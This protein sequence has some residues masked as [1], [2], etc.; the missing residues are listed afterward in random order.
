MVE[1]VGQ[2][3][4]SRQRILCTPDDDGHKSRHLTSPDDHRNS[5]PLCNVHHH[6]QIKLHTVESCSQGGALSRETMVPSICT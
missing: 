1:S 5:K 2:L 6:H 4:H 3:G